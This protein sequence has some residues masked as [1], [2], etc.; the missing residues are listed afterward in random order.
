MGKRHVAKVLVTGGAGFIGSHTVDLLLARG[1]EVRVLDSLESQVHGLKQGLP[2][3]FPRQAEVM[4]G[5]VEDR[6]KLIEAINDIDAVI[7]LAAVVGIAQSMYQIS[8]YVRSNTFGTSVLLDVLVNEPNRVKKLIVASSMSIYGEGQYECERCGTV[9]PGLRGDKELKKHEWEPLCP[10]CGKGIVPKPTAEEKLPMPT[11]IYAQTKR[12]EEEMC[13]LVGKTYGIPTIA[14]RYFNVY[15]TRQSLKNPYTGV[16]AIF[17]NRI[18]NQRSPY[19][20]EDGNQTRDFVH[21]K[22]VA[23]ANLLCLEKDTVDYMALNIG[24]GEPT[25]IGLLARILVRLHHAKLKPCISGRY[26]KGDIRHCYADITRAQ[27]YLGY[28]PTVQ[29]EDGMK[30]W[31]SWTESNKEMAEDLSETAVEEL[32]EKRLL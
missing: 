15:G 13:L 29:L 17:S 3:H 2:E 30:E 4:K 10:M 16:C 11:S 24:T 12:H 25:P 31:T 14:L 28:H 9:Y 8:R 23:K 32:K 22:D 6:G 7:H 18:I 1:Y 5:G 27:E 26:R 19:I 21:V 20:F